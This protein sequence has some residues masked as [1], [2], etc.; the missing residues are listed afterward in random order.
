V[1]KVPERQI[2]VAAAKPRRALMSNDHFDRKVTHFETVYRPGEAQLVAE[3]FGLLGLRIESLGPPE[4]PFVV[5]FFGIDD[6]NP[7]DDFIAGSQVEPEQWK[8]DQELARILREGELAGAFAGYQEMV[9]RTPYFTTHVGVRFESL[10]SWENAV[11]RV[12]NIE[13]LAPSLTGR[14]ELRGLFRPGAPGSLSDITH[15]AFV[16][17]DVLALGSL[18]FGMLLEMQYFD[19]E[20]H[21][22]GTSQAS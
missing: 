11:S 21:R 15:Q 13:Q 7:V 10:S 3:L 1:S 17:N 5:G 16:W 22:A 4:N 18:A 8:F 20:A 14:V 9:S 2:A 19:L 12:Q 6:T